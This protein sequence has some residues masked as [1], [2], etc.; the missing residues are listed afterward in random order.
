MSEQVELEI[1]FY[2]DCSICKGHFHDFEYSHE[3]TACL[4]SIEAVIKVKNLEEMRRKIICDTERNLYRLQVS[5][6]KRRVDMTEKEDRK[7]KRLGKEG[8]LYSVKD[9]SENPMKN[10]Y[11]ARYNTEYYDE[12]VL[13][14]EKKWPF[15]RQHKR[16]FYEMD[17]K[18][19][20]PWW[21]S[22]HI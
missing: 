6:H 16:S 14:E 13:R 8:F 22:S 12:Y 15:K 1:S 9:S 10:V 2:C 19:R 5:S 11:S 21:K 20:K 3:P 17:F 7:K 18:Q 4:D